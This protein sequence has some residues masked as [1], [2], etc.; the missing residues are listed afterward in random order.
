MGETAGEKADAALAL[1]Y[2]A[3]DDNAMGPGGIAIAEAP[4]RAAFERADRADLLER[5]LSAEIAYHKQDVEQERL[6]REG[7]G[8]AMYHIEEWGWAMVGAQR[9]AHELALAEREREEDDN[10]Q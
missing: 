6:R 7:E 4:I 2:K 8:A 1:A 10:G 5:V 3:R 9:A